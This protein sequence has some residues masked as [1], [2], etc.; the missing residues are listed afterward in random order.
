MS[1]P[2]TGWFIFV[3]EDAIPK[4]M[5]PRPRKAILGLVDM[6][7]VFVF[8]H[9]K[10]RLPVYEN[11]SYAFTALDAEDFQLLDDR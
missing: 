6:L 1:N 7:P 8:L 3:S 2:Q 5:A 9:L 11:A 4:P 10:F